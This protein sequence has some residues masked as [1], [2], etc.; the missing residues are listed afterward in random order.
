MSQLDQI[1]A[2]AL[3]EWPQEDREDFEERAAIIE[4]MGGLTR[5]EAERAAFFELRRARKAR[6]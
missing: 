3:A 4:F 5:I 1:I 6:Q 2:Q